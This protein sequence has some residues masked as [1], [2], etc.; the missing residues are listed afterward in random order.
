MLKIII[1]SGNSNLSCELALH[2][3]Q[4][5]ILIY[6]EENRKYIEKYEE[7]LNLHFWYIAK[8]F[9]HIGKQSSHSSE[10]KHGFA[11]WYI[12]R[13]KLKHKYMKY[14]QIVLF[15]VFTIYW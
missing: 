5:I 9:G 6:K 8:Q 7:K 10:V 1:H 3:L 13:R 11:I 15:I 14:I 4:C 2:I 12:F